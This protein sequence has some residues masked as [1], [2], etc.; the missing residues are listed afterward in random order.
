MKFLIFVIVLIWPLSHLNAQTIKINTRFENDS[1]YL[2]FVNPFIAPIEINLTPLDSTKNFIKVKPYALLKQSGTFTNALV[3]PQSKVKDTSSII[4]TD[5][6]TFKGSFGNPNSI[7]DSEYRYSLPYSKGKRYKIVQSFGGKFSHNRPQ[8]RYAIDFNTKIG[9]TITASRSG[10]VFY[11]KEDS[12]EYCR[13]RKCVDKGNKVLILHNDGSMAHY[14]HLKQNGALVA[15]GDKVEEGQAIALSGMTG[16]TTT[17]HLHFVLFKAGGISIPFKFK[18]Q[19]TN[20]LKQ[21]KYYR[22]KH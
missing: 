9:D 8:S 12:N 15:T 18:G 5:Y 16:F 4:S 7:V 11:V 17:P 20:K 22:R 19:K 13:T 14:V 6:V 21:G 1:V 2:D 10:T 3:I